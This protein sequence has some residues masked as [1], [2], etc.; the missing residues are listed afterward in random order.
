MPRSLASCPTES[1]AKMGPT[2][3]SPLRSISSA[4]FAP[5]LLSFNSEVSSYCSVRS[6]E[7][8]LDDIVAL[9]S[10]LTVGL[11]GGRQNSSEIC[12]TLH[13]ASSELALLAP[14]NCL[15]KPLTY[16]GAAL[17]ETT[18]LPKQLRSVSDVVSQL[19]H[20]DAYWGHQTRRFAG[21]MQT[22]RPLHIVTA[23]TIWSFFVDKLSTHV[24]PLLQVDSR[25]LTFLC[26]DEAHSATY[27]QFDGTSR[28]EQ[29]N[30]PGYKKQSKSV[31]EAAAY[32]REMAQLQ[33]AA[34]LLV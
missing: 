27:R 12:W 2:L 10:I 29:P 8:T 5:S 21:R 19:F 3:H 31:F 32:A 24:L 26:R 11:S 25:Y 18:R 34:R 6:P 15:L 17:L 4:K 9:D 30:W 28:I 16:G 22:L 1:P 20:V 33:K 13:V 23:L 7:S 14:S